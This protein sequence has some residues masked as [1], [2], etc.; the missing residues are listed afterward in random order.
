MPGLIQL[1]KFA[2]RGK[3]IAVRGAAVSPANMFGQE[4]LGSAAPVGTLRRNRTFSL[5][6]PCG[7]CGG[8]NG[9][10]GDSSARATYG[11]CQKERCMSDVHACFFEF[12]RVGTKFQLVAF[13]DYE[14]YLRRHCDDDCSPI[15]STDYICWSSFGYCCMGSDRPRL[16]L[17]RYLAADHQHQ[18]DDYY[19]SHGLRYSEYAKPGWGGDFRPNPTN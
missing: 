17:F 1:I 14:T 8:S 11:D 10:L 9:H 16:S 13:C 6:L 4:R 19:L 18:H 3:R 12:R 15:R 5:R 7:Q 2:G